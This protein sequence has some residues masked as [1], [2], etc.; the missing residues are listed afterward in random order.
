V[1]P[2]YDPDK[3][4]S[5][6]LPD[7]AKNRE[8][9]Q[10]VVLAAGS[11][12]GVQNGDYVLFHPFRGDLV[13]IEGKD[14]VPLTRAD[15]VARA[16][17]DVLIPMPDHVMLQPNWQRKYEQPS[18]LLYMP[19]TVTEQNQPTMTATILSIGDDV[20]APELKIGHE[21]IIQ[22]EKGSEIGWIDQVYYFLRPSHI[23][24]CLQ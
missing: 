14:V 12:S 18:K 10:G 20:E 11:T 4:G 6:Y 16:S 13:R 8:P 23:L 15:L 2:Y 9:Q 1:D 5:L 17:G 7:M 19:P 24:A 22:P 3:I 21:V